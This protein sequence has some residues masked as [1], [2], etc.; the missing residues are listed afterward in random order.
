MRTGQSKIRRTATL[1]CIAILSAVSA[2]AQL[3]VGDNVNM[4][5]TG[6]LG[7]GYTGS[8]GNTINSSHGSG[9]VGDAHLTGYYFHPN[10]L[11]FDVRPYY[12]RNQ[13]SSDS[14]SINRGT[15][16]GSSVNLFGG[17][18]FPGSI[19][20]GLDFSNNSQ[21]QVGG[22]SSL[23]GNSN[24]Q[25]FG[26]SWSLLFPDMPHVTASYAIGNS[27]SSIEGLPQEN[28]SSS[29][30]F[31]LNSG[32][33]LAGWNLQGY[34]NNVRSHFSTL[35]FLTADRLSSGGSSTA[36]GAA[37]QHALPLHG[38]VSLGWGHSLYNPE[39]KSNGNNWTS[40]TYTEGATFQ[41]WT[42]LSISQNLGYT[43]NLFGALERTV[44]QNGV[45]T[46]VTIGNGSHALYFGTSASVYVGYGFSVGSYFNHR[47]QTFSNQDV[48]DSQYGATVNYNYR[49]PILGFIYLGLG[50]V[51]TANQEG[52]NGAA[53]VGNIG[54]SKNFGKWE[55]SADFNYA[56]NTQTLGIVATTSSTSYGGTLRR[57]FTRQTSWGVG[58]RGSHSAITARDGDANRSESYSSSLS[59]RRFS[60][61]GSYS[62]SSGTAV[63]TYEGTLTSTPLGALITNDFLLFNARSYSV[64]GAALLF[65]RL[66]VGGGYSQFSS[67]T[68]QQLNNVGLRTDGDLYHSHVDYRLRKFSFA[69]GYNRVMQDISTPP[70]PPRTV[71]TFFISLTRWFNVF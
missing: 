54:M 62:Q 65:R 14:Q 63:L 71:N 19:S 17:S 11:T 42:R 29:K 16:I 8:F 56:Q 27:N 3:T 64:N 37:A 58:F 2:A 57:R 20:Y 41:P 60:V 4:N 39:D 15:G 52:N 40:T 18:R 30:T 35:G 66:S 12:D 22:I 6:N 45:V 26:V 59:W 69:G 31:S 70:G 7:Y 10:F 33:Q 44:F 21:F 50:V 25:N 1:L 68:L 61:G 53:L 51:N 34:L 48:S 47:V 23:V 49:H 13:N 5:L 38:S 43:T 55:T 9:V 24:G 28:A 46:P 67:G 36:F 32:Y